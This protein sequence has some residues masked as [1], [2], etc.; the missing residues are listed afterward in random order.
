MPLLG[1]AELA[2]VAGLAV[3]HRRTSAFL[4]EAARV[5]GAIRRGD[6]DQRLI[7]PSAS[8]QIKAVVDRMNGLIDINDAF[9]REAALAMAA[10]SEGRYYRKI[11]PEGMQGAYLK[12]VTGINGAIELM[13]ARQAMIEEAIAEVR[14]VAAAATEGD[15]DQRIDGSRF[16]GDYLTVTQGMNALLD[17][18]SRPI[19]D[20]GRVLDSLA[21]T[22]LTARMDGQYRGAFARLQHDINTVTSNMAR[23]MGQLRGTARSLKVATSEILAGV[24]DLSDR[25]TKQ[26]ATIEETSAAMEQLASTVVDNAQRAERRRK[27]PGSSRSPPRK[28]GWS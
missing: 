1:A 2:L 5:C 12:S 3:S 27:R 4:S 26:A 18:V 9:V 10:V 16:S 19:E 8:G 25:T 17:S 14:R 15:L 6:F 7:L 24:N 23:I 28:A 11:R 22:N 20:A 13:A 21:R